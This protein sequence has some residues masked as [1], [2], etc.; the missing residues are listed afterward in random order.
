[1]VDLKSDADLRTA[2]EAFFQAY[3]AFTAKPDQMLAERGLARVHHRILFFV[4]L[5]PGLSVKSL[6]AALG[7]SK[8]AIHAP[9]RQLVELQLVETR[10]ASH[11]KRV[12]ELWLTDAGAE[13]ELAL[14]R[15]QARLLRDAFA[16]GP[17]S[18]RDGWLDGNRRLADAEQRGT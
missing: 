7:V 17:A 14:H 18:T 1:M 13:L 5:Y 10:I 9:L 8:Q 3:R 6:L 16:D 12:R 2:M 15:E 4:A 11:D